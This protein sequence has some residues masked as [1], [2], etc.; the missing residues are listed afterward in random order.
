MPSQG[1]RD[2][3]LKLK[4]VGCV[5]LTKRGYNTNTLWVI[6]KIFKGNF[7]FGT[8][9]PSKLLLCSDDVLLHILNYDVQ[10]LV[11]RA[12]TSQWH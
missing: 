1:N 3:L 5:G 11:F 7:D 4:K 10:K 6:E 9:I 12:S 2:L 8:Q